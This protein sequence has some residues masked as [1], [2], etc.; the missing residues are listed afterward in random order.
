MGHDRIGAPATVD[1]YR[2]GAFAME[3]FATEHDHDQRRT[4]GTRREPNLQNS[5]CS[6]VSALY[7]VSALR[8]CRQPVPARAVVEHGRPMRVTTDR[9]G[10]AGGPVRLAAGP[11]RTSGNWWNSHNSQRST[12]KSHGSDLTL[13]TSELRWD[14]EEWDVVLADG[15][16]YC[17]FQDRETGGWF[18]DGVFD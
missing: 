15:A 17:V 4:R 12:L 5:A 13:E 6:A 9:R 14:R 18:I 10:F 2:P 7:V 1:S 8:R 3:P 11:W 16:V